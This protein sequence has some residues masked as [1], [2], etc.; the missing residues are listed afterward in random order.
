[1][2]SAPSTEAITRPKCMTIFYL[3]ACAMQPKLVC[4]VDEKCQLVE[5]EV[6]S[7]RAIEDLL[8]Q[9]KAFRLAGFATHKTPVVVPPSAIVNLVDEKYEA[10]DSG[11][12][13]VGECGIFVVK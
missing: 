10:V 8:M 3:L 12:S 13:G 2:F 6:R 1:M 4:A 9:D 7:G 5:V 11:A